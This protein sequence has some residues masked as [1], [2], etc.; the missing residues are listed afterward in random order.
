MSQSPVTPLGSACDPR[1][2][3]GVPTEP[4]SFIPGRRMDARTGAGPPGPSA[5]FLLLLPCWALAVL[6]AGAMALQLP[7]ITTLRMPAEAPCPVAASAYCDLWMCPRWSKKPQGVCG[8]GYVC[9]AA[10]AP[11]KG[12]WPK[13]RMMEKIHLEASPAVQ[14]VMLEHLEVCG[15]G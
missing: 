5:W 11:L 1:D 2:G 15:H 3:D 14:E 4:R 8:H 13:D 10:G 6:C 12:M 7:S 9:A